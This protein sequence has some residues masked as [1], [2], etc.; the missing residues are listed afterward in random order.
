MRVSKLINI[1]HNLSLARSF[2]LSYYCTFFAYVLGRSNAVRPSLANTCRNVFPVQ[3]EDKKLIAQI[4]D[5]EAQ[6][7]KLRVSL[8]EK[9]AERE[10]ERNPSILTLWIRTVKNLARPF[11]HLKNAARQK[12]ARTTGT[13]LIRRK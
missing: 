13:N 8:N 1:F 2:S 4:D 10:K 7:K 11:Q 3:E 6:L 9:K 12:I 5:L